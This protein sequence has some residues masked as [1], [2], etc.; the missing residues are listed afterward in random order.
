MASQP[1][2]VGIIGGSGSGKTSFVDTLKQK[3]DTQVS[4]LSL[5]NYYLPREQQ[6]EDTNG[7]KNFDRPESI[8]SE[9]LYNDLIS[10]KSG[11]SVNR[12][13]YTFNN[14]E[15]QSE[16]VQVNPSSVIVLEGLFLFYYEK[17]KRL[18]DL[19]VYIHA[20]DEL[21]LIRRI[22]RDKDERNYPIEDVTYRYEHHVMPSY[23][24][25]I[26]PFREEADIV[27]NNNV[28]YDKGLT[29]LI[30]HIQ[31]QIKARQ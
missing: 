5:D 2:I 17:V 3:L 6:V 8:Q 25:Y 30:H 10:L 13:K 4:F 12:S 18:L 24:S 27:I 1:Y 31:S 11:Q 29:I 28:T 26:E 9:E 20:R 14:A 16:L 19:K 15:A 22:R 21:K 23:R 7:I